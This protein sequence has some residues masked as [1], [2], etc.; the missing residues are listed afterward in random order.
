MAED[1]S[2]ACPVCGTIFLCVP[3]QRRYCSIKCRRRFENRLHSDKHGTT[4]AVLARRANRAQGLCLCGNPTIPD[5]GQCYT[6]A[7]KN[8]ASRRRLR[9]SIVDGYGGMCACCGEV[10]FIFLTIDHIN[11]DGSSE[12]RAE[13]A[14]LDKLCRRIKA[15]GFPPRY[16]LLCYNC[17]CGKFRNGG[18]CP[19]EEARQLL[20]A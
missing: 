17:N 11:N 18:K 13:G 14:S 12:R 19:H 6:C 7:N 4:A 10:E 9:Q 16:Q 15:E 8:R 3:P 2:R 5:A 1:N 20:V